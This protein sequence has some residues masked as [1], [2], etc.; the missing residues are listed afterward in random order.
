MERGPLRTLAWIALGC[1]AFGLTIWTV[2]RRRPP[3][4]A[5]STAAPAVDR[6]RSDSR[7]R[8]LEP[9]LL[10]PEAPAAAIEGVV[11]ASDGTPAEG[12]LVAMLSADEEGA[13]YERRPAATGLSRRAG[14]FR[15]ENLRPGH[16]SASATTAAGA[17]FK[18]GLTLLPGET[19]RGVE[20]V[21]GKGGVTISGAILD[22]GGGPIAAAE[23]RAVSGSAGGGLYQVTADGSGHYR[24]TVP[25]GTYALLAHADGYAAANELVHATEDQKIDFRLNPAATLRGR[26]VA[27]AS[28]EPIPDATVTLESGRAGLGGREVRSDGRGVFEYKDVDP[29]DYQLRAQKGALVGQLPRAVT[30]TL[31]VY[32]GDLTIACDPAAS[33]SGRVRSSGGAPIAG[34]RL[35]LHQDFTRLDRVR[36]RSAP[37]GSYRIEGVLP[38]KYLLEASA[39][40][41]APA[42]K[43]NL[44]VAERDLSGVDLTLGEPAEVSGKV[45]TSD[46]QPVEGATV[47]A[48]TSGGM[49]LFAS[50]SSDRSGSD[51]RFLLKDLGPGQLRLQAEHPSK[52]YALIGPTPLAAG[53]K[54]ELT[55]VLESGASI[56]GVVKW[57]DGQAAAGISVHG[58]SGRQMAQAKSGPDGS[59]VLKPLQPGQV[60]VTASRKDSLLGGMRQGGARPTMVS[61]EPDEHKTGVEVTVARGG[62]KISGTVV[63]PSGNPMAGASV[64]ATQ[65]REGRTVR[66]QLAGFGG[67]EN[68][69]T[70]G[71][72]SFTLE[73]LTQGQFTVW[74][75]HA[76]YPD[77]QAQHI[78]SDSTGVRVQ[79][80]PEAILAGT[81]TA[82]GKTVAD[83]TLAV[84]PSQPGPEAKL[85]PLAADSNRQSY[86][87]PAGAFEVRGLAG[88]SYEVVATTADGRAG[89][90]TVALAEGE[91]RSG[92]ELAV[93]AG[94]ALKGR[95]VD[96]QSGTPVPSANMMVMAAGQQLKTTTDAQGAF[97]L[98]GMPPTT[99]QLMFLA[100]SDEG[101]IPDLWSVEV[102][103]GR[104]SVDVGTLRVL[105]GHQAG[106]RI[107][108]ASGIAPNQRGGRTQVA[109]VGPDSAA[110]RAGVQVGE[111]IVT[112]D[113]KPVTGLG[114][115]GISR[116]LEGTP[117]S[118]VDLGL[119]PARGGAPRTVTLIRSPPS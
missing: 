45:V 107:G 72:G 2:A 20:L 31:A 88:G 108:G 62:H 104:D 90:I 6:P 76:G 97:T 65:E 73:D 113:A 26:V 35:R 52:G 111:F 38:G 77:A 105:R 63:D 7:F 48:A 89:K 109:G 22:A 55:V 8:V 53:E 87:D 82:A 58:M 80:K 24:M 42:R 91:H 49:L 110:A 81:V 96:H 102:P 78:S 13:R 114:M 25:K 44:V 37:D 106:L 69:Y 117:G 27:R 14:V 59:F 34:A 116:L 86:H 23:L 12:A 68:V 70:S 3:K 18:T 85:A 98:D 4:P 32:V 33:I 56:A 61:L 47:E 54:K 99:I 64:S 95:L 40:G 119:E 15:I 10:D 84:Q 60:L 83:F 100:G 29:G 9:W 93:A 101:Y 19:L 57:D 50:G 30:V 39:S 51:G 103:E 21:L 41:H 43:D 115:A 66:V 112:I 74:A 75:K 17:G 79:F 92:L 11:R 28:G 5:V 118:S 36:T 71:D 94:T 1:V 16:Y 46:G 67:A